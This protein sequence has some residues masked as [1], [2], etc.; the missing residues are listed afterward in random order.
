M[1]DPALGLKTPS[2][3]VSHRIQ[4]Q[5]AVLAP[6]PVFGPKSGR[7]GGLANRRRG[8]RRKPLVRTKSTPTIRTS[9]SGRKTPYARSCACHP[10]T[11]CGRRIRRQPA[12][13]MPR[14]VLG[15]KSEGG[16]GLSTGG[17]GAQKSTRSIYL[18]TPDQDRHIRSEDTLRSILRLAKHAPHTGNSVESEDSLRSCEDSLQS[19]RLGRFSV[20]DPRAG[21]GWRIRGGHTGT[22]RSFIRDTPGQAWCVRSED[23]LRSIRKTPYAR[24]P[25]ARF[26]YA[27]FVAT[28]P[29]PRPP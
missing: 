7:G 27:R 28:L 1:L 13:L 16:G 2:Q 25:Y 15:P 11:R 3:V 4:R 24:F 12:V 5:P 18:T 21:A 6:R 9:T 19:W 20:R 14:A 8:G 29:D 26:P 22:P 23:T 17:G 10:P